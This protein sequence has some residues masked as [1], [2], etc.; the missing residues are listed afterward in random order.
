MT[1][2]WFDFCKMARP[3]SGKLTRTQC[4]KVSSER[5]VIKSHIGRLQLYS[6][7]FLQINC[8]HKITY[9]NCLL[10]TASHTLFSDAHCFNKFRVPTIFVFH[11]EGFKFYMDSF[12]VFHMPITKAKV[13]F[14]IYVFE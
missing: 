10:F 8:H 3:R 5:K 11:H 4:C 12:Q 2:G 9:A 13:I 6:L 14:F 1:N 7:H